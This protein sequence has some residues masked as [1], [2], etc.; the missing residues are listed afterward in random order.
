MEK[1]ATKTL[2]CQYCGS[3]TFNHLGLI[4]VND[5]YI[6]KDEKAYHKECSH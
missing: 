6:E 5:K 2:I 1:T 3:I 4:A